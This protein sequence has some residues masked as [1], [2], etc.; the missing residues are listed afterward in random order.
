MEF[1]SFGNRNKPLVNF[2]TFEQ[3]VNEYK[4]VGRFTVKKGEMVNTSVMKTNFSQL[5]DKRFYFPNGVLSVPYGYPSLRETDDFK[6][7]K[8]Q[9]I[10]DYFWEGKQNLLKMEK[11]ALK[12]TSRLDILNQILNQ[13]PKIINL[14]AKDNF[15]VLYPTKI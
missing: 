14:N 1:L 7:E 2:D 11:R 4:Q 9:K 12:N 6:K 5:N 13:E 3:P 8:G 10:E 15:S